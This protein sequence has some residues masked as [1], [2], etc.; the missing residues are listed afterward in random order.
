MILFPSFY[1]TLDVSRLKEGID[2]IDIYDIMKLPN[3]RRKY[4]M[5]VKTIV[6]LSQEE[7]SSFQ[8]F[9]DF[10]G[11]QACETCCFKNICK[12]FF[13]KEYYADYFFRKILSKI[14][15]AVG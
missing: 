9:A 2:K 11:N 12:E 8:Q 14:E 4:I 3:E 7:K 10:C 1:H 15:E 13:Q 6:E 5:T